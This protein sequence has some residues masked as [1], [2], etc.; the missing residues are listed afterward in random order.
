MTKPVL[1]MTRR[2]PDAVEAR[3]QRDYVTIPNPADTAM[4]SAAIV[5]A[6]RQSGAEG[7]LCAAGDAMGAATLAALPESVRVIATFSVGTDHIDLGAAKAR[8]IAVTNTPDVLS[9]ATAEIAFLLILAAARRG[10]EAERLLRARQWTGWAPT[11]LMGVTLEGKRLGIL[12]MGR[13]GQALARMARGFG[14]EIHYRNRNRLPAEEEQ[15]AIYHDSDKGFLRAIDVL[16]MHIPG[17]AATRHW[18]D[19]ERIAWLKRGAIVVNTGRGTTVD[20]A[21]LCAA[22]HSGHLRAAGLDVFEGE[23]RI[24]EGYHTAPNT[25]LL[26]HLGSATVETRDAMGFRCLDN[27]DAVLLRGEAPLHPVA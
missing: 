6:A 9:V 5:A 25:V 1:L 19:A 22:L 7:I 16:S 26:P 27:L 8:G 3:A 24:F 15:G 17:G 23:P 11:Q 4:E 18:L 14:M 10:G 13:I 12:G 20:D 21:A 2:F